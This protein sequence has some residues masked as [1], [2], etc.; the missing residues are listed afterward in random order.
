MP[1][2]SKLYTHLLRCNS[3]YSAHPRLGTR[4]LKALFTA[5]CT[6][7]FGLTSSPLL[8]LLPTFSMMNAASALPAGPAA[9]SK[10]ICSIASVDST[11]C[12]DCGTEEGPGFCCKADL[13]IWSNISTTAACA[14]FCRRR[15]RTCAMQRS[16]KACARAKQ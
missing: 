6:N 13:V 15:D 9:W 4:L 10:L 8:S 1:T 14:V 11:F 5:L 2:S 12:I 3:S 7:P 16:R